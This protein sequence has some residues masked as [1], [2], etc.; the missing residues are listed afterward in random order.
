[1]IKII[2][3]LSSLNIENNLQSKN[4]LK[5]KAKEASHETASFKFDSKLIKTMALEEKLQTRR[6]PQLIFAHK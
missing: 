4:A 3:I 6:K 5:H 1:M 2:N